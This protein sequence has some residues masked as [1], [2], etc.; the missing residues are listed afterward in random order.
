VFSGT[1]HLGQ[2][3]LQMYASASITQS[4]LRHAHDTLALNHGKKFDPLT[5]KCRVEWARW[6]INGR[7]M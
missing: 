6:E 3:L 2:A 4:K 7:L 5:H 1:H